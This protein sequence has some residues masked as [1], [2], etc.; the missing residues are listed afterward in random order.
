MVMKGYCFLVIAVALIIF[1]QREPMYTLIIGGVIIIG[2]LVVKGRKSGTGFLGGIVGNT[3]SSQE[4]NIDDLITLIMV[5]QLLN[6]SNSSKQLPSVTVDSKEQERNQR[7]SEAQE[8][9]LNLFD[10]EK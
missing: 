3:Q 8:K 6:E 1:Y 5:Q 7:I 9:I 4:R 2:Y 10:N